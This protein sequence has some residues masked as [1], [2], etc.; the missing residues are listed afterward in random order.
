MSSG[1]GVQQPEAT[2]EGSRKAGDDAA[3]AT[4]NDP[5]HVRPTVPDLLE[6][7]KAGGGVET[8]A[9]AAGNKQFLDILDFHLPEMDIYRKGRIQTSPGVQDDDTCVEY[10]RTVG[11]IIAL[12]ACYAMAHGDEFGLHAVS[13][14]D[15]G[16]MSLD[17]VPGKTLNMGAKPEEYLAFCTKFAEC[18]RTEEDWWAMLVFLA[19]HDVGKSENFRHAVN[20]T[21]PPEMQ[22]D[23]HDRVLGF[24]LRS[25]DLT[26][27]LLPSVHKLGSERRQAIAAGFSTGFQ[28]PQ[29]GQGEISV[30]N[31]RGLLKLPRGRLDDGSLL[32]YLYHSIFDIAG[33]L[34]TVDFIFPI[35]LEPVYLGFSEAMFELLARLAE[36]PQPDEK[37]L[38]FDFLYGNFRK[39]Y[40][41][42]AS[43]SFSPSCQN[44]DFKDSLGL[45]L[46]RVLALTRNTYRNPA[47]VLEAL[48]CCSR[49]VDEMSG[50]PKPLGP[51]I[52]LYYGPDMLRLG[53][54]RDLIDPTGENIRQALVALEE[55]YR[56]GRACLAEAA[57]DNYQ[58]QVNVQPI[59]TYIKHEGSSWE[60][61]GQL[62]RIC[63]NATIMANQFLTEGIVTLAT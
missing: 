50:H 20:Q 51:Q 56:V 46:L 29:L 18:I 60:G 36:M 32:H 21:L 39:S 47:A 4:S 24:A 43:S 58:F 40:P 26:A 8:N 53:L 59:V 6:I 31:L 37:A 27:Q 52:M 44:R 23:D 17:K 38:Y 2:A 41:D 54:G 49:L 13:R 19:V 16:S 42:F 11:T 45:V 12:L 30:M 35:A 61:G 33:V 15:R 10:Y 28:L 5:T 22:S 7:L 63:N 3:A 34:C 25:A 48:R 14:G 1:L 62:R 55:I 57:S 9:A